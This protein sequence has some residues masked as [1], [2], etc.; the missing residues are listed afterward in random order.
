MTY[1]IQFPSWWRLKG[2]FSSL[3]RQDGDSQ[4]LLDQTRLGLVDS[5]FIV[6]CINSSYFV[7]VLGTSTC[8]SLSLSCMAFKFWLSC[9]ALNSLGLGFYRGFNLNNGT[10]WVSQLLRR[11]YYIWYFPEKSQVSCQQ[12]SLSPFFKP[13]LIWHV[14]LRS[15]ISLSWNVCFSVLNNQMTGNDSIWFNYVVHWT[16]GW[17]SMIIFKMLL[18]TKSPDSKNKLMTQVICPCFF[19]S[20]PNHNWHSLR[21]SFEVRQI[22]SHGAFERR[23]TVSKHLGTK[24]V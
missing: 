24:E 1:T 22:R 2:M 9:I 5:W 21:L 4:E 20:K 8:L 6:P 16:P 19:S 10:T 7:D 18:K 14:Q 13:E 23:C 17:A 12:L 15:F 3:I 11:H